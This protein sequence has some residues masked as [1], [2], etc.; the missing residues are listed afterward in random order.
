MIYCEML[1]FIKNINKVIEDV[2]VN[3]GIEMKY[4]D[5]MLL[6]IVISILVLEIILKKI[7]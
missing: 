2:E 3:N 5:F 1:E 6:M 7:S 4:L